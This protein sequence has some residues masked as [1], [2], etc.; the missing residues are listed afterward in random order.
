MR[1]FGSEFHTEESKSK[2]FL[3]QFK[4]FKTVHLLS[5]GREA[6]GLVAES[7]DPSGNKILLPAYCCDSMIQPFF[8]RGWTI[9]F[10]PL[11]ADLSVNESEIYSLCKKFTPKVILIMNFF[12]LVST[13]NL[14][15]YIKSISENILIIED[16]T[17]MLFD[18]KILDNKH[19]D[20]FVASIRKWFGINDGAI[21][22]TNRST[23]FFPNIINKEFVKI[24]NEA[25]NLKFKYLSEKNSVYK[26]LYLKKIKDAEIILE[27]Y[28]S[29][30]IISE[31]SLNVLM[32]LNLDSII[33]RRRQ[34]FY[35]LYNKIKSISNIHYIEG[36]DNCSIECPFSLPIIIE[37][38]DE[39]QIRLAAKGLYAP[40]LWPINA[41]ARDICKISSM[42][43]DNMLSIPIDQRFDYDDIEDI[44]NIIFSTIKKGV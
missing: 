23:V 14:A 17:H 39:V 44:A 5:A 41:K 40:V 27:D 30:H 15:S 42:M 29:I 32:D 13:C 7:I 19:V 33:Y 8:K 43:S 37:K 21:L 3:D 35:H 34:N 4:T 10:Y 22:L 11:N 2:N 38:R 25:Q 20:F 6:L 24:R 26:E 31:R 16:F 12:G 9:I 36:I 18:S 28:S 1:E